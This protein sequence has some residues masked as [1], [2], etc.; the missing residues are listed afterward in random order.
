MGTFVFVSQN[1]PGLPGI[2]VSWLVCVLH[3]SRFVIDGHNYGYT[4]MSLS[5]GSTH[6]VVRLAKWY[7]HFFGP[8]ASHNLCVTNAMKDDLQ[9]NWGIKYDFVFHLS[10]CAAMYNNI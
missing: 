2:A 5:H 10:C 4:I 3:G 8:L 6:P 9:K 7:E 1:P